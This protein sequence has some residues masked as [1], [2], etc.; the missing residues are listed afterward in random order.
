MEQERKRESVLLEKFEKFLVSIPLDRYREELLPIKTVEQDLPKQLN[1]LPDIYKEYWTDDVRKSFATFDDFFDSWWEGK[2]REIDQFAQRYFW[3][4]SW[5]FVR[6][7][8]KARLYRTFVSVLT[9]FHFSYAWKSCCNSSL[10]AEPELDMQGVDAEVFVN[11]VKVALQIK[12]ETYRAEA[13]LGGRFVSRKP[14]YRLVVEVPYTV[15]KPDEWKN[16]C[17][18]AKLNHTRK[19]YEQMYFL[20][21]RLQRWLENGFV[22]FTEKYPQAVEAFI[23]EY[24]AEPSKFNTGPVYMDWSEVIAEVEK[25]LG[26]S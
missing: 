3:G 6:L 14:R 10:K 2:L 12:K 26:V 8:F 18:N 23:T 22:V 1:P 25:Q 19:K 16:R 11:N 7:G 4:C 15:T 24:V 20:A 5:K 21:S 13:S 17:K 9:Q